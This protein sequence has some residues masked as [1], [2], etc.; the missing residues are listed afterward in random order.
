MKQPDSPGRGYVFLKEGDHTQK[1]DS[2]WYMGQWVK[3]KYTFDMPWTK[4]QTR[5]RR[6]APVGER[7]FL[8]LPK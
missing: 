8:R 2:Y 6:L 1:G 7:A 4:E 5:M 3:L